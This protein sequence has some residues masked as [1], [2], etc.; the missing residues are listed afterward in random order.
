MVWICH[1]CGE[2]IDKMWFELKVLH[3]QLHPINT[4]KLAEES[5]KRFKQ[6]MIASSEKL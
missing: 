5:L 3:L 6:E 4:A 2:D 1:E